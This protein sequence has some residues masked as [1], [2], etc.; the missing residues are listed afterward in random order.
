MTEYQTGLTKVRATQWF[1]NGDHPWD[2]SHEITVNGETFLSEGN[3][4]RRFRNPAMPG[5]ASCDRCGHIFHLHGWLDKSE[6]MVCPSD[7]IVTTE[8]GEIYPCPAGIFATTYNIEQ[9]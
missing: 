7:F 8:E 3:L 5:D 6:L 9:P 1:K 4:V 2:E